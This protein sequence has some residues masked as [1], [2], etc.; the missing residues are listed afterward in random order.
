M[1]AYSFLKVLMIPKKMWCL[2][3][4]EKVSMFCKNRK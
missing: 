1:V 3:A 4:P 2:D